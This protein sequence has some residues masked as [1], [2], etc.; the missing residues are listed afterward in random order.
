VL[1]ALLGSSFFPSC[2]PAFLIK[3]SHLQRYHEEPRKTGKNQFKFSRYFAYFAV[4]LSVP[5][6]VDPRKGNDS[7]Q[8]NARSAERE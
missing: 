8:K 7:P 4:A 2:F 5:S 1:G 6:V 3:T